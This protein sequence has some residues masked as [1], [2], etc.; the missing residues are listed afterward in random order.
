LRVEQIAEAYWRLYLLRRYDAGEM[1]ARLTA[2]ESVIAFAQAEG[3][4][5][6]GAGIPRPP[7][8]G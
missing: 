2:L 4:V 6:S 7:A 8:G 1:L 3:G 5:C